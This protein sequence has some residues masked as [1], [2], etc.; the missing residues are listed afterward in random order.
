MAAKP[1]ITVL[2]IRRQSTRLLI[3][4]HRAIIVRLITAVQ[5]LAGRPSIL[6][7]D[8]GL[9]EVSEIEASQASEF[10]T[11]GLEIEGFLTEGLEIED[12]LTEASIAAAAVLEAAARLGFKVQYLRLST[13]LLTFRKIATV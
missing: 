4:A 11:E 7:L 5:G 1:I 13:L 2:S 6:T 8:L 9:I 3:T 10:Q 12:S